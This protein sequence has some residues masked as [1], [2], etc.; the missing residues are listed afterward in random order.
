[1][2]LLRSSNSIFI[3]NLLWVLEQNDGLESNQAKKLKADSMLLIRGF[4]SVANSLS[5]LTSNIEKA[6]QVRNFRSPD[7]SSINHLICW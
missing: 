5:Q 3:I 7:F 2:F 6:L 1:M 4:D